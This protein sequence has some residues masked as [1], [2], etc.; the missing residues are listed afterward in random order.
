MGLFISAS[1]IIASFRR[2]DVTAN[3]IANLATPGFQA[4]T[5]LSVDAP[6]GGTFVGAVTRDSTPGPLEFTGAP[7]DLAPESGFFRVTLPD[8]AT[9]YTRSG[10]FGLNAQGQVV[11][12][13][14]AQ[15]EPPI[16]VPANATSVTVLRDGTVN[17]TVPGQLAPQ[18]AGQ[19]QVFQFPNP[20]G[21]SALGNGLFRE[22]GASGAANPVSTEAPVLSGALA[23]SNVDLSTE[24]VNSLIN[25]HAARANLNAFRA[26]SD[27]LG[28][29]LNITS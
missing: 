25:V 26:Q 2:N 1:G 10:H 7:L 13:G 16:A 12:S 21:L 29:L 15:L 14:G 4:S 5:A 3:N 11:T 6:G 28:E 20:G 17:A 19:I 9:A 27:L 24:M 8:G 22:T 23:G 18:V